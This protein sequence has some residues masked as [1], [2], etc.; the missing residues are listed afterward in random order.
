[1]KK[2]K[3]NQANRC[4]ILEILGPRSVLSAR[5]QAPKVIVR[6]ALLK[7]SIVQVINNCMATLQI[8]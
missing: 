2:S 3:D 7:N 4:K 6:Q 8:K 1:M 5:S